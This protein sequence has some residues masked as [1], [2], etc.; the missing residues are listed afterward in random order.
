MHVGTDASAGSG[1]A[2]S[3][4]TTGETVTTS[5]RRRCMPV[6]STPV[7]RGLSPARVMRCGPRPPVTFVRLFQNAPNLIRSRVLYTPNPETGARTVTLTD[8]LP[9]TTPPAPQD[10]PESRVEQVRAALIAAGGW[11]QRRAR[12]IR[13]VRL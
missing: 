8:T 2:A 11:L 4:R 3:S 5:R 12:R 1:C 7:G 10:I 6:V 13:G 9:D